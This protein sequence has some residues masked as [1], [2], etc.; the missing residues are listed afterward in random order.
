[1]NNRGM[2]KLNILFICTGNTC[3]SPMAEA[4][5]RRVF[6][7][8]GVT[9][10]VRSCGLYVTESRAARHAAEAVKLYG[11]TLEGHVPRGIS[12]ELLKWAD[13]CL[14]MTP[15]HK[16][17][18][19]ALG[20]KNVYTIC[21]YAGGGAA[22]NGVRDPY[23][24]GRGVYAAC[25]GQLHGLI[26][27]A[28]DRLSREYKSEG[29][30]EMLVIGCDHGGFEMKTELLQYLDEQ[31]IPY[32]DVGAY[33]ADAVDY[34]VY[35]KLAADEILSGRADKGVLICG[36]GIGISIAANKIKGIRAAVCNDVYSAKV[37]RLHNDAN[38][39]TIGARVIGFGT[40]LEV[41]KAFFETGFSGESRHIRRLEQ[42]NEI[43][44]ENT[45]K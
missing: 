40:A 36:T 27:S 34:P 33:S 41:F 19:L 43:E 21:E 29:G 24:G 8:K 38:V 13:I 2:N 20:G 14:A 30:C 22:E 42:I 9:A 4:I 12:P 1:M 25:A 7:D 11:A 26:N 5:A 37:T 39:L 10:D 23:G 45:E 16:K 28:A 35:A 6:A 17:H 3:R 44:K 31:K 18:T 15:E 32:K